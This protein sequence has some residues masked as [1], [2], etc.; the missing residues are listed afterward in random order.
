MAILCIT[1][2]T[3]PPTQPAGMSCAEGEAE[4]HKSAP[5][6]DALPQACAARAVSREMDKIN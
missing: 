3:N 1:R 5:L 6:R 4:I 2:L